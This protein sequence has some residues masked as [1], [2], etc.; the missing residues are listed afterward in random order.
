MK[1]DKQ[2]VKQKNKKK[3][4]FQKGHDEVETNL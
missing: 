4:R 1:K 2:I 3:I